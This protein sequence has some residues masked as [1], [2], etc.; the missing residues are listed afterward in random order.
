MIISTFT[1]LDLRISLYGT[2]PEL[3]EFLPAHRK[4]G[5]IMN[6]TEILEFFAVRDK[7]WWDHDADALVVG[8]ADDGEL[9]SPLWG[10]IKGK[11][12]IQKCYEEWFSTF[13]DTEFSSKHLLIDGDSAAQFIKISGTQRKDFCGFTSTGKRLQFQGMSLYFFKEGKISR[14]IRV[15]DFTGVLM[16]LGLLKVKPTF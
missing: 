3:I 6:R 9:D 11:S 5:G 7:A 14:E 1:R 8:H 2:K 10:N 15:Y 4:E 12:A 16:Q 13:P